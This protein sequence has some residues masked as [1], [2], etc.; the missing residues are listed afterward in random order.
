MKVMICGNL[1][2]GILPA[3]DLP[4]AAVM[5][6]QEERAGALLAAMRD[7]QARG[8]EV[9]VVAGG[10]FAKG[11]IAQGLY[12][13]VA[14]MMATSPLPVVYLPLDGEASDLE[15]RLDEKLPWVLRASAESGCEVLPSLFVRDVD[16]YLEF[17][18]TAGRLN[19]PT[20]LRRGSDLA[21][22]DRGVIWEL[23]CLE[24]N[25]FA[26]SP[27]GGYA[28]FDL[29]ADGVTGFAWVERTEHPCV[30]KRVRLDGSVKAE[31]VATTVGNAVKDVERSACLRIELVGNLPLETYVNA[32]DLQSRIGRHFAYVEVADLCSVDLDVDELDADLSLL[33][34]FVRQVH[35]DGSLSETE[36]ARIIRCGWS[37]LNG[38]EPAE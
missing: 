17:A 32:E 6:W 37:V 4:A 29:D 16:E 36:K 2:I 8:A 12:K 38:K 27:Y 20:V 31:D 33:A 7:A 10:L 15:C 11:F 23:G 21:L 35:D 1:N 19:A 26:G 14:Q 18:E 13:R 22:A 30:V 28:L 24:P 3:M 25:G 5:P 9:C 34:E